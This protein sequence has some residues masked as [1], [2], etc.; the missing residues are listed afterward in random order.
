MRAAALV[1]L[2]PVLWGATSCAPDEECQ[3]YAPQRRTHVSVVAP[4]HV[5]GACAPRTPGRDTQACTLLLGGE[6]VVV[7]PRGAPAWLVL[8]EARHAV[9]GAWHDEDYVDPQDG[10]VR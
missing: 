5:E 6:A 10:G 9:C 2:T 7:L 4:E 3:D 1:A 8:H